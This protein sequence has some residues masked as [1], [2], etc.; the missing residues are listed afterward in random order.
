MAELTPVPNAGP[1]TGASGI[2]VRMYRVGFGDFFLL[3]LKSGVDT[4]HILIDCG[5]HAKPTSS[6]EAAI[7]QMKEDTGG[8][9]ALIIMTH[10]HADH[11][12]GFAKG[13]ETFKTFQVGRVWMPWFEDPTNASAVKI[14]SGITAVA[15]QLQTAFAASAKKADEQFSSMAG[16]I[17][18]FDVAGRSSNDIALSVLHNGFA[19]SPSDVAYLKAGDTAP[20]PDA[21]TKIGLTAQILGP[22][23]DPA[24]IRQMDDQNHQYLGEI[25]SGLD[26][27]DNTSPLFGGRFNSDGSAYDDR[28]FGSGGLKGVQTKIAKVQPDVMRAIAQRADNTLNNQSVVVLFEF[29]GKKL[30]FA[31]DAQWGNWQHMLFGGVFGSPGHTAITE[32]AKAIL[33]SID[34]YKVGHHGSTNATPIDALD[35]MRQG[36]VAMCST[37]E[38]AYGSEKNNSEVPRIPLMDALKAKTGGKLA[39]SDQAPLPNEKSCADALNPVFTIPTGQ[40]F[41]DYHF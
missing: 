8:K 5:V 28:S 14:Q 27:A 37:A 17:L 20:L 31:G 40:L 1:I 12:S 21:L 18:G 32:E 41:I 19:N 22:P 33:K 24:L 4:E 9:L 29:N 25:E 7:A 2:R 3:S 35:A 13:A 26:A 15:R 39:R 10:R 38:G 34:F 16:N 11:I 23:I 36:V 6:I 30:L